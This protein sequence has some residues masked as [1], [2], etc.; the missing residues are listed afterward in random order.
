MEDKVKSAVNQFL[1]I[2]TTKDDNSE[3]IHIKD[4]KSLVEKIN[5]TIITENGKQLLHG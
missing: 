1:G 3:Y 5:K 2:E 4:D